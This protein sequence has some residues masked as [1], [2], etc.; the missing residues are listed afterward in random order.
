MTLVWKD[1]L[2]SY[3]GQAITYDNAGNPTNYD[4]LTFAWQNGNQLKSITGNGLDISYKYNYDGIRTEK[5]VNG[6]TTDYH[7]VNGNV[8]FETDGTDTIYYTYDNSGN[9]LSMNLN[10]TEYYYLKNAQGDILGLTDNTGTQVVSY[11]YDSW[12]KL[13][14]ITGSLADTIGV[15]NPYR[16]RGYRYDTETG[17][18]YLQSRYYNPEWGRFINNDSKAGS[19]G[20]LLGLNIFA[21]CKNNAINMEDPSGHRE[22]YTTTLQDETSIL[23]HASFDDMAARRA[24]NQITNANMNDLGHGWSYRRE[25][26]KDGSTGERDHIQVRAPNG[27]TSGQNVNGKPHPRKSPSPPGWVKEKLKEREGWDWDAKNEEWQQQNSYAK[28]IVLYW[29]ISEGSRIIPLRDIIP[30]P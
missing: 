5:T 9:I 12:G 1:K 25:K 4:G 30:I 21:Y 26:S 13:V 6:I 29:I 18:Y 16:Y 22:I 17:L 15:K 10:G 3:D 11:T 2:A 24:S 14:S 8:T 28:I 19:V 20:E 23:R 27:K 7:L